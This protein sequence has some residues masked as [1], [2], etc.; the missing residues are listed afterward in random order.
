MNVRKKYIL[1]HIHVKQKQKEN[2]KRERE[3]ERGRASK[4]RE[5]GVCGE[6][7]GREWN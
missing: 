4:R 5:E 1:A 6:R 2:G 7:E 3:K